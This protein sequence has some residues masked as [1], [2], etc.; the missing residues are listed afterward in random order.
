[1][2]QLPCFGICKPCL[3]LP[4]GDCAMYF[5]WPWGNGCLLLVGTKPLSLVLWNLHH[6]AEIISKSSS[7]TSAASNREGRFE[8]KTYEEHDKMILH[9]LYHSYKY[10]LH[11]QNILLMWNYIFVSQT[12]SLFVHAWFWW[13][14]NDAIDFSIFPWYLG[15]LSE[16]QRSMTALMSA[17]DEIGSQSS[18]EESWSKYQSLSEFTTKVLTHIYGWRHFP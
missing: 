5:F 3:N 2:A 17:V 4:F 16:F 10:F 18:Q 13:C 7:L 8:K 1:M 9:S 11:W 6:D 15:S 12:D 14:H